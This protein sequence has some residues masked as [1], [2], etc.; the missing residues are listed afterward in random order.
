M[1]LPTKAFILLNSSFLVLLR[2]MIW[3]GTY[4]DKDFHFFIYFLYIII[5]YFF[6]ANTLNAVT[7]CSKQT[8]TL[9]L[10]KWYGES[11]LY[12]STVLYST[13]LR[14]LMRW[15]KKHDEKKMYTHNRKEMASVFSA[16]VIDVGC[17]TLFF[18]PL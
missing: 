16:C 1:I 12:F 18:L 15:Y 3:V 2:M 7:V 8:S 5:S 11:M 4:C 13:Y 10:V 14:S 17:V 9:Y 6:P